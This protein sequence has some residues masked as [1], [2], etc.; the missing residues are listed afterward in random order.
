LGRQRH[1]Q[2]LASIPSQWLV[3]PTMSDQ[4]STNLFRRPQWQTGLFDIIWT[5][6]MWIMRRAFDAKL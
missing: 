4:M 5:A 1:L 2:R 3:Y 6:L